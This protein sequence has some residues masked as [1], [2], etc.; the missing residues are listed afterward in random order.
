MVIRGLERYGQDHVAR[1]IAL[2]HLGAM[3]Q[4]F[5][6]TGTI[7]ENYAPDAPKQGRPAKS[8]FVGWSGL[9]PILYL[10][11][12]AIG[13]KPDAAANELVWNL[14]AS[15]VTGCERFRFNGHTVSLRAGPVASDAPRFAISITSDGPFKLRL[16]R[17]GQTEAHD[18]GNGETTI[19]FPQANRR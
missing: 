12:F 5:Q 8:D 7:W 11:E 17:D 18:V 19:S 16:R 10:L 1:E 4:V 3:A 9:G 14:P 6:T 13:L 15:S 2:N